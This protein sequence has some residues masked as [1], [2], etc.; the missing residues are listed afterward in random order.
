MLL[1]AAKARGYSN[2][3]VIVKMSTNPQ[4]IF[5]IPVQEDTCVHPRLPRASSPVAGRWRSADA[6]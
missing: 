5:C 4:A 3:D 6:A 1:G 2:A